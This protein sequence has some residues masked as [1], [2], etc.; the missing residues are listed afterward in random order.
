MSDV[1]PTLP[2]PT[3]SDSPDHPEVDQD[4]MS[5]YTWEEGDIELIGHESFLDDE[6]R[7]IE[8][9]DNLKMWLYSRHPN[10]DIND[11]MA[12]WIASL[13]PTSVAELPDSLRDELL[14]LGYR[15]P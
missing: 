6:G 9:V 4:R 5:N 11:A 10:D 13:T 14:D 12:N 3:A 8:S 15:L 7:P 1:P 2:Q